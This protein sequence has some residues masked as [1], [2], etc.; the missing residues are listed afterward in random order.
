MRPE[1]SRL[2]LE[3]PAAV[4]VTGVALPVFLNGS[5]LRARGPAAVVVTVVALLVFLNGSLLSAWGALHVDLSINLT[6][7]H[8]LR[9]GADPYGVTALPERAAALGRPPNPLYGQLFT[10]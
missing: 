7:A 1:G 2:A 10:S 3:R 6:A 4:V 9:D 8:A 5:P